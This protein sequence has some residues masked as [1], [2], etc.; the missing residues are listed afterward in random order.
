MRSYFEKIGILKSD[1]DSRLEQLKQEFFYGK[2]SFFVENSDGTAYFTDTGN[3]DVRTEGMSYGMMLCVELNMHKEFDELW[4]WAKKYM[5]MTEG[6]NAG[7]FAW[8][9]ATDGS[10]NA[11]G[12]APDGEEFFA[13]SLIF[14]AKRWGNGEGIFCYE[15]EAQKLLHD[16]ISGD[17]VMFH[18]DNHQ[19]LFVPNSDFTDPSYHLPHFYRIFAEA[20]LPEDRE[21]YKK[22]EEVSRLYLVKACHEQTGMSSEYAEFDGSRMSRPLEWTTDR[23]DWFFSDAYRTVANIALDFEWN[24]ID[25]GQIKACT[26]LQDFLYKDVFSNNMHT[27]EVNGEIAELGILHPIGLLATCAQASLASNSVH[28]EE[29]ARLLWNTPLRTGVRRYYDNCLYMFAFLALSGNYS[30]YSRNL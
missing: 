10:K 18:A 26:L 23:H 19:I 29:Y 1:I 11:Y 17:S 6:E 15:K 24:S 14:A 30:M 13:M 20:A 5:Y 2:D 27:Y 12:P 16:M 7:F 9:C 25:V 22:A 4:S 28:A 8:S 3:N 21:F